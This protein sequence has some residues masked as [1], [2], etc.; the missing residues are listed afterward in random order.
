MLLFSILLT[1]ALLARE[2]VASVDAR[3]EYAS[4]A[5]ALPEEIQVGR[6]ITR[7]K[8]DGVPVGASNY[9]VARRWQAELYEQYCPQARRALK[10]ASV[11]QWVGLVPMSIGYGV[12]TGGVGLLPALALVGAGGV[13]VLVPPNEYSPGRLYTDWRASPEGVAANQA[14]EAR[15]AAAI[16][17]APVALPTTVPDA[18]AMAGMKARIRYI[19]ALED[20]PGAIPFLALVAVKDRYGKA[21]QAAARVIQR[22]ADRG[23]EP[24]IP[25]VELRRWLQDWRPS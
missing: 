17:A 4:G 1:Q 7:V 2:P 16:T 5:P 25:Y 24:E 11:K 6:F 14:A 22:R 10:R 20:A 9:R 3:L 13:I 18:Y 23:L 21:R 12:A 8:Q 19:E 15:L